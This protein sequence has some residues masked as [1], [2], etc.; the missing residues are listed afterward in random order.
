MPMATGDD[1]PKSRAFRQRGREELFP[2]IG[3]QHGLTWE[4]LGAGQSRSVI[5]DCDLE[6]Q[7]Q[8]QGCDCL[9]DMSSS[10]DPQGTRRA[11]GFTVQ[12][13]G[14]CRDASSAL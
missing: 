2:D 11:N 10:R 12:Q 4:K 8:R 1:Q 7:L 13:L 6:I 14:L 3:L 5:K 9:S